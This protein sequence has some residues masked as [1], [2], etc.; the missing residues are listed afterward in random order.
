M[1]K[2]MMIMAA[3]AA[4][5]T[6]AEIN[7]ELVTWFSFDCLDTSGKVENKADAAYPLTIV[8]GATFDADDAVGGKAIAFPGLQDQAATFMSPAMTNC[9]V[10]FW[11][12]RGATDGPYVTA[13]N[14]GIPYV[15]SAWSTIRCHV[16][17]SGTGMSFIGNNN[18]A[19]CSLVGI[20]AR[21]AWTHLLLSFE[22]TARVNGQSTMETKVYVDGKLYNTTTTTLTVEQG[23]E[24]AAITWLGNWVDGKRPPMFKM[25][26]FRAWRRVLTTAEAQEEYVRTAA[27]APDGTMIAHWTMD[28]ITTEGGITVTAD[29]T[30]F[31]HHLALGPD[32]TTTNDAVEGCALK[33]V[34]SSNS[35]GRATF[36]TILSDITYVMW[37]KQ[38][39]I[40]SALSPRI[41]D[42]QGGYVHADSGS[43]SFDLTVR[44]GGADP[45]A[46]FTFNGENE[47]WCLDKGRWT[48]LA[49]VRKTHRLEDGSFT[50]DV[51]MY[52]N[53]TKKAERTGIPISSAFHT[54]GGSIYFFS[55]GNS[56]PIDALGDEIRVFKGALSAAHIAEIYAGTASVDAGADFIT[57]D[58][59]T[60]L[61]G[62]VGAH[63]EGAYRSGYAGKV[64][65]TLVSAPTGGEGVTIA[66]PANA[67]TE[68]TL[69]AEG[70]YTFRLSTTADGF[71]RSDDVTVT[72]AAAASGTFP[73]VTATA[74][75]AVT[76]PLKGWLKAIC[77]DA[78]ARTW[79]SK[80]S[81]P[82]GVWFATDTSGSTSA[83]FSAAGTYVLA[84]NAENA[85]GTVSA[86]TTV[87]VEAGESAAIP[88]NNLQT[89]LSF[90]A[91]KLWYDKVMNKDYSSTLNGT[92]A[93][94][95]DGAKVLGMRVLAAQGALPLGVSRWETRDTTNANLITSPDYLTFSA[96]MKYEPSTDTNSAE[97]PFIFLNHQS[98][99]LRFGK[100]SGNNGVGIRDGGAGLTLSQQGASGQHVG[101]M[102]D[103]EGIPSVTG[104]WTHVCAIYDRTSGEKDNFEIWVDGVKRTLSTHVSYA[105][106]PRPARD[107]LNNWEIGGHVGSFITANYG[108]FAHATNRVDGGYKSATFPG[109]LDEVRFYSTKLNAVQIRALANELD[110][111]RNFAP[112]VDPPAQ[113]NFNLA[114]YAAREISFATYDDSKPMGGALACTWKVVSGDAT[115]VF[116]ADVS[117]ASTMVYFTAVGD[118]KL[119]L[120][121]TD[122]ERTSY[123]EVLSATVFPV[124]TKV[125]V[126]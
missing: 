6:A 11:Y 81:G 44:V 90:N 7:D 30:P 59:A 107:L 100:A 67:E 108:L 55:N 10:A 89:H 32:V 37:T 80:K 53:G 3:M 95:V 96:W 118:Y 111:D 2:A 43:T 109:A 23:G 105:T 9:T 4:M 71:S 1:K 110:A 18:E 120:V 60:T 5:D 97:L 85:A 113:K 126:R 42:G 86:E 125:I 28:A 122:G 15:F 88:T 78:N 40:S 51:E 61:H 112:H 115:K 116:F 92:T 46:A 56:R 39:S 102:C 20:G 35:W 38:A 124:G 106:F 13:N 52:V 98:A 83:Y 8:S 77:S 17:S 58:A 117:A 104:R 26:E 24:K 31:A 65:W 99:C 34:N 22:E 87:T 33:F 25:D 76:M 82:G 48:H 12:K 29:S 50:A 66:R 70:V 54:L 68:V 57:A 41:I 114:M 75:D 79:W 27:D 62:R 19:I 93:D 64:A 14:V 119:Q 72:R 49:I 69:P 91:N 123:S 103:F 63:A 84:F 74:Q 36:G 45:S 94:L 16:S 73:V 101:L 21:N 121:A 47:P